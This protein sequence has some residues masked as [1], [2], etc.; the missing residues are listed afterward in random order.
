MLNALLV[1]NEKIPFTDA[2]LYAIIGFIFVFIGI[3]ILIGI[4]Y[5]VGFVMQKT[6][7]KLPATQPK[8]T[9][10]DKKTDNPEPAT[11]VSVREP[12]GI[13]DE[14]KAAIMAAIMAY[15]SVEKPKCEFIIKKIKKY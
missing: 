5:L 1:L 10:E 9:T 7:G 8:K 4:L 11:T 6:N 12:E 2:L 13:S 3:G 15:Y 14:E